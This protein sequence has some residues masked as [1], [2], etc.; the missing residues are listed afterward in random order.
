LIGFAQLGGPLFC[1]CPN[2]EQPHF[3]L[4]GP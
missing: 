2:I 1:L 3:G 4:C